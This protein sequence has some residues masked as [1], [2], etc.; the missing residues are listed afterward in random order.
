MANKDTT[1]EFVHA[2]TEETLTSEP[3]GLTKVGTNNTYVTDNN[4][5]WYGIGTGAYSM[6]VTGGGSI[7]HNWAYFDTNMSTGDGYF[8]VVVNPDQYAGDR[9]GVAFRAHDDTGTK[10]CYAAF[11]RYDGTNHTIRLSYFAGTS[12]TVISTVTVAAATILSTDRWYKIEVYA[13]GSTIKAR[14]WDI[15]NENAPSWQIDTTDST[16]GNTE[17]GVGVYAYVGANDWY[18][19]H[20]EARTYS[21]LP[22]G[23][24]TTLAEERENVW[25]SAKDRFVRWDGAV[26]KDKD[27]TNEESVSEGHGYFMI[28][29]VN[30]NDQ[31]TFDLLSDFV[32]DNLIGSLNSESWDYLVAWNF[33]IVGGN[34]VSDWNYASD[35]DNDILYAYLMAYRKWGNNGTVQ[36]KDLAD[37]MEADL[38]TYTINVQ[39]T[40]KL[41]V[42]YPSELISTTAEINPSYFRPALFSVLH[43]Y[44]PSRGW[45]NVLSDGWTMI[46]DITDNSGTL[47]TTAGLIPD[48]VNYNTTTNTLD[49]PTD[50]SHTTQH[51]YETVRVYPFFELAADVYSSSDADTYMTGN[52]ATFFDS[53]FSD[54]STVYTE[55]N[56][57][58]TDKGSPYQQSYFQWGYQFVFDRSSS[59][60]A[61]TFRTNEVDGQY[62][63]D[64]TDATIA[65][66]GSSGYY[67]GSLNMINAAVDDGAFTNISRRRRVLIS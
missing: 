47:S 21:A 24:P 23:S 65:Y 33:D 2:F 50:G 54:H 28:E 29:A 57:D 3:S 6:K 60:N 17:T 43:T 15:A 42:P 55:Y 58:G 4:R 7:A 25:T 41:Q 27:T 38:Y 16:I 18:F 56:H 52:I 26:R 32:Q 39:G 12:E 40:L 67:G 59:A 51:G 5:A 10:K 61:S 64:S 53:E 20:L 19:D 34:T 49:T 62:T 45:N 13:S 11:A 36:Y 31:T 66:F 30:Q 46:N 8:S 14:V 35:A 9:W 44:Y 48:W 1:K 37:K 22:N 63:T